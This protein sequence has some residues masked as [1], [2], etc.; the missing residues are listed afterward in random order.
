MATVT[1]ED[2]NAP[3]LATPNPAPRPVNGTAGVLSPRTYLL[4]DRREFTVRPA[5]PA[6]APAV[7]ALQRGA[8]DERDDYFVRTPQEFDAEQPPVT[9]Q[10]TGLINQKNSLW[11]VA[12]RDGEILGSLDFHGG[13]YSIIRHVGHFGIT[14]QHDYRNQG[15]GTAL[16]EMLLLWACAHPVVEKICT[17]FFTNNTRMIALCTRFGFQTEGRRH[18]E[19]MVKPGRYLDAVLLSKWVK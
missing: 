2:P 6:D 14:V 9:D 5:T 1:I 16:I 4:S 7:A 10:L 17:T 12:V 11:I 18:R 13:R 19:Y 8:L 15:V 3:A